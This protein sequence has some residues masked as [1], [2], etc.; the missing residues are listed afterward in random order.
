VKE[1]PWKK[2]KFSAIRIAVAAGFGLRRLRAGAAAATSRRLTRHLPRTVVAEV[3]LLR[4]APRVGEGQ[5]KC[6]SLS[7]ADFLSAIVT[8]E[9]RLSSQCSSCFASGIS[10][11]RTLQRQ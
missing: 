2:R 8:N 11:G 5:A 10:D 1:K 9:H 4:T 7:F 3:A 6:R